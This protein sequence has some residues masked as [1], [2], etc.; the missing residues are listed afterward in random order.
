M[1]SSPDFGKW[2]TKLIELIKLV[3]MLEKHPLGSLRL[4]KFVI[5]IAIFSAIGFPS[6][7]FYSDIASG[8]STDL[9]KISCLMLQ[10]ILISIILVFAG[11]YTKYLLGIDSAFIKKEKIYV[12][13]LTTRIDFS[14]IFE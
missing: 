2:S 3:P 1:P 10:I 14:K 7:G 9:G 6:A 13:P 5:T 11:L 8:M 4:F 12:S